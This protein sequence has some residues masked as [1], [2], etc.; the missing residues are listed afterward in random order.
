MIDTGNY[1]YSSRVN[2]YDTM[3]ALRLITYA[4]YAT[5]FDSFT[6]LTQDCVLDGITYEVRQAISTLT[7]TMLL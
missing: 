3:S 4:N 6:E 5:I 1:F 2:S 7:R